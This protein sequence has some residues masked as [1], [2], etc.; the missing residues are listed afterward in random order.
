MS[1]IPFSGIQSNSQSARAIQRK[2]SSELKVLE[3]LVYISAE[4]TTLLNIL[5]KVK[6][7]QGDIKSTLPE[8]EGL[9]LRPVG[10]L[11][12]AQRIKQKYKRLVDSA[13]SYSSLQVAHRRGRKRK[14]WKL[15][16]VG[17]KAAKL[18]EVVKLRE[19][20]SKTPPAAAITKST[21][22]TPST[23]QLASTAGT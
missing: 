4:P 15:Q 19:A 14:N 21:T 5:D 11:K 9:L 6:Q 16:R 17:M 2:I 7:L 23:T 8:V 22:T 20:K 10:V 13:A 18:K 12:T 3:S 1:F